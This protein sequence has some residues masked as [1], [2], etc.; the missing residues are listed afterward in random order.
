[1]AIGDATVT[2]GHVSK[3]QSSAELHQSSLEPEPTRAEKEKSNK[4]VE[5]K[6]RI[7]FARELATNL[8]FDIVDY[9]HDWAVYMEI[10]S[11]QK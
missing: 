1:M 10:L 6:I 5:H 3:L 9:D 4:K 11:V 7:L 2:K 8:G